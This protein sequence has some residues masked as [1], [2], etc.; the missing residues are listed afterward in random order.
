M[1]YLPTFFLLTIIVAATVLPT[2]A[3]SRYVDDQGRTI[4]VDDESKI[5]ARYLNRS[6]ELGL[7]EMT[8]EQKAAEA[9]RIRIEREQQLQRV[10]DQ[11]RERAEKERQKKMET[12]IVVRGRQVLVPIDVGYSRNNATVL[13]L[14]DT[15]ASSTVFHSDA[16]NSLS[17]DDK[18]GKVYYG[19]VVGGI[20]VRT[21]R[22]EFDFIKVGPFEVKRASAH[23]IKHRDGDP[24]YGG[25]LGMD[26]LKYLSYEIDYDRQVIRWQP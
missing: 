3:I 5:P 9:E 4:F 7:K 26:F 2:Y 24:G 21:R 1:K 18:D 15:G 14:L 23:I 19:R 8:D 13:M 22:V 20:E 6:Q 17:I 10:E 11:R 25:L 12:P 16:L